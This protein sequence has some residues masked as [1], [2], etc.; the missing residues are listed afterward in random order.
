MKVLFWVPYPTEGASNRYRIEQYLPLLEK[1]GIRCVVRP[2]WTSRAYR[3]LYQKGRYLRKTWYFLRGALRRIMDTV[4]LARYDAIV[5]HREAFPVGGALFER[6]ASA[7]KVPL[8]FDFDDA[9]FLPAVSP[10][11]RFADKLKDSGKTGR[12]ISLSARVIAGNRYLAD[13]ARLF[14]PRTTVIA[15]SID[16]AAYKPAPARI[17]KEFTIGWIG[18]ITTL[19][20]LR[21]I[22][23]ALREVCRRYPQVRVRIVGGDYSVAGLPALTS[24][25]WK[26]STELEE[27]R[28]FDAGV[29]P[30]PDTL[31]TRG[32]CAFKAILYMGLGIP[33]VASPVGVINEVIRHGEN[34]FLAS[35]TQEWVEYLSRLIEDPQE[36]S[37][38]S[39]AARKTVEERFSVQANYPL[40]KQVILDAIKKS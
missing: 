6:L 26:L 1:E 33:S 22:E 5:V 9:I 15:T 28:G 14:N 29:M 39:L 16:C 25:L 35:T 27:L 17:R 30:M 20:F 38:I 4:T 32:K 13:Y 2:F 3:I 34:G 12:I 37:K 21:T 7:M 10:S 40:F 18:S 31:W 36:R 23:D 8:V 11:N 19:E 24:T